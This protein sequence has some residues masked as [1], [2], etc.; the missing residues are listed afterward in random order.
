MG[1]ENVILNRQEIASVISTLKEI[2]PRGFKSM[3]RIVGLVMFFE[4]KM[5]AQPVED[6]GEVDNGIS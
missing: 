1:N 4:N 5:N 2:K 6:T 3:D